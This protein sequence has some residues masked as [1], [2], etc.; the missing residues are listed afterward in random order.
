LLQKYEKLIF[1]LL[2][3]IF[4]FLLPWN[5]YGQFDRYL[6]DKGK[7]HK[8]GKVD[9]KFR[10]QKFKE[11]KLVRKDAREFYKQQRL[12]ERTRKKYSREK[13]TREVQKRQRKTLRVAKRNN[14]NKPNKPFYVRLKW[15]IKKLYGRLH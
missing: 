2:T 6:I 8:S 14:K 13:Q 10:K 1:R 15:G 9:L 5:L 12:D 7:V 3:I 11:N 4:I